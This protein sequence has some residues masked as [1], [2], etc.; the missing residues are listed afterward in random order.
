MVKWF[1]TNDRSN[2]I[3]IFI[4]NP[5][6]FFVNITLK[7]RHTYIP[8][9]SLFMIITFIIYIRISVWTLNNHWI[10]SISY[11]INCISYIRLFASQTPFLVNWWN[12]ENKR[13]DLLDIEMKIRYFN[14]CVLITFLFIRLHYFCTL[15]SCNLCTFVICVNNIEDSKKN[16]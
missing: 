9:P 1:L 6:F 4:T 3:L 11:T 5:V 12:F 2:S 13:N 15:S 8:Y 10:L 7:N 16:I 14:I